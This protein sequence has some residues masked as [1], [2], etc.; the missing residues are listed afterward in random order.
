MTDFETQPQL[1]T[2]YKW[3]VFILVTAGVFLSTMDSSMVNVALPSIMRSF[4]STLIQTQWVVLIYLLTITVSLLF[5]GITADHLGT[6][7]VYLTGVGTFALVFWDYD[8]EKEG[9]RLLALLKEK[10]MQVEEHPDIDAFRKQVADLKDIDLFSTP[11]VN[12]LLR[13][14]IEQTR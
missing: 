11:E 2:A 5:W 3:P 10:G 14:V 13:K 9:S 6:N 8:N 1:K 7:S 12:P 4:S